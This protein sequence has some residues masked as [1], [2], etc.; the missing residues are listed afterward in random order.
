MNWVPGKGWCHCAAPKI[1]T[2]L[3]TVQQPVSIEP[4]V[5]A[6]VLS[7]NQ[8]D[9]PP[10]VEGDPSTVKLEVVH[11]FPCAVSTVDGWSTC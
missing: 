7:L 11:R 10:R 9:S 3:S 1:S 5:Q 4:G 6:W 2:P 8:T